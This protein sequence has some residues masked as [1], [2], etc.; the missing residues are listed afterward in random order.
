MEGTLQEL[1]AAAASVHADRAAVTYDCGASTVAPVSLLYRDLITLSEELAHQLQVNFAVKFDLIGLYYNDDLFIPVWI[2]GILFTTNAYVPLGPDAPGLLSA[3]VMTSSGLKYC[4]VHSDLLQQF[5]SA[6]SDHMTVEIIETLPKFKL[7]LVRVEPVPTAEPRSGTK[8]PKRCGSDGRGVAYVLHTSGTTGL[9]KIVRVPH[10]CIL[11][12]VLHLRSL[13]QVVPDDVIFLASPL[14]FD[15]SVVDIFVALSSGA[16]LLILPNVIKKIP[17]QLS[18]LLFKTHKTT[19]LQATPT[20]LCRFGHEVLKQVVLS[21]DSSLRVL[22]L[23]GEACP[24]PSL[25][26]SW[27]HEKNKTIIFNVYGITEVSCWAC[28]YEIPPSLLF[29]ND[30]SS[31]VPLGSPLMATSVEVMDENGSVVTE[32][33]GQ[34]FIG[35]VNR[36]CLLDDEDVVRPGTMRATGD[37]VSVRDSQLYYLGR[38]DRMIKRHGKRVNLDG[39]QQVIQALPAVEACAVCLHDGLRLVAFVVTIASGGQTPARSAEHQNPGPDEMDGAQARERRSIL[40]QLTVRLPHYSVPDSLVLVSALPLTSHGKVDTKSLLNTYQ[41]QR[42]LRRREVTDARTLRALLQTLWLNSLGLNG[43]VEDESTF[44]RSGGDSLKA[45]RF[46]EDVQSAV[47][48]TSAQLLEV[49]LEQTFSDVLHHVA[50]LKN[51]P[52]PEGKTRAKRKAAEAPSEGPAERF[53]RADAPEKRAG[54]VVRRAADVMELNG[55][56]ELSGRNASV[57]VA[58]VKSSDLRLSLSWSSD[59]G[60]CVDASPVLLIREPPPAK[61]TVFIGSHSHR[62]Q[63]LE[64]ESGSLLWERVLSGRIE[65]SAAVS[66]CG[67]WVIVGCYDGG[68]HF[69]SADSGET[70]WTFEVKDAVKSSAVVDPLTGLVIVG[71]H[72]GCVYALDVEVH[73]C[74]WRHQCAAGAVFSSPAVQASSRRLYVA[75]LGGRLLCLNPSNGEVVWSYSGG[76][77]FFS[78]PNCSSGHVIVGS[79][80]GNISCFSETGK[81]LWQHLTKAPVFSSPSVTPDRSF[82]LCGS[83][84]GLLHCLS[85]SDGSHVWSFQTSGTVYSSPFVFE[86]S[87][88]GRSGTL[89]C[90]A[91]T[92]GTLYVLDCED[93]RMLTSHR[94]PGELFSS[95]VVYD[96]H[97]V[98][99]CRNDYV[100]CLKLS[101]T[102]HQATPCS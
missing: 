39:V 26:S 84:D 68:V 94:L 69:L 96:G 99:G 88:A 30:T 37:W 53:S 79:V 86:G 89:V 64:L 9:P 59:T 81:Q 73:R 42:E 40:E 78:S 51:I 46:C 34:V 21:S 58:N 57:P 75:T 6:V 20:L 93:G 19:V 23:G 45:V 25:L 66:L 11:P 82:V 14:T 55:T 15:P 63:A 13:F 49:I 61:S 29:S 83:H 36:V 56:V 90:V 91:S 101:V 24:S 44:I 76:S 2:L 7:T 16:Q 71:S 32:G 77:P 8:R 74:V 35:G 10:E 92:D 43:A 85:P 17:K 52:P 1:V 62:L 70:E 72:D 100:Y 27:K 50:A 5:Q 3:R 60:R 54:K 87:T 95:P 38:K 98:I 31:S 33:E 97:V 22:A 48:A 67:R 18:H 41:T 102:S 12:N 80:D 65:A 4:A 47:G 28:C